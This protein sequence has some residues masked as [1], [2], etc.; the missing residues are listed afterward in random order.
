M[1]YSLTCQRITTQ[2][3]NTSQVEDD[4]SE[5]FRVKGRGKEEEEK[6]KKCC[7]GRER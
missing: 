7:E 5:S 1:L 4:I 3:T 6:K 2:L